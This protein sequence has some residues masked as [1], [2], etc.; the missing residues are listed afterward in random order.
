M[1]ML[2]EIGALIAIIGGGWYVLHRRDSG[3]RLVRVAAV[4]LG[5]YAA[6]LGGVHGYNEILQGNGA[7]DAFMISAVGPPCV[8]ESVW[9]A[10]LPALTI[11][12]SFLISGILVLVV[13]AAILVWTV[14]FVQRRR[15]GLILIGLAVILLLVGGGFFPPFYGIIAGAFGTRLN[16]PGA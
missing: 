9:H 1:S 15:G 7:P 3:V 10:C 6:L 14:G 11:V 12:P 8:P 2:L 13:C 16:R 5:V 4:V